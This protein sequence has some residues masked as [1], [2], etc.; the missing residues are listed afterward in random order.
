MDK[1]KFESRCNMLQKL[2]GKNDRGFTLIELM[3]VIAVIG[4]LTAIAIPNFIAYRQKGYDGT[5][6]S[7]VRNAYTAAQD[8]FSNY[9]TGSVSLGILT[10]HGYVQSSDVVL[11]VPSSG[12]NDL[13]IATSHTSGSRTYTVNSSGSIS[14]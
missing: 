3:I 2:R 9:P 14:F 10:A 5:A 8:Y 6:N 11:L 7:D 4:I 12:R 13:Q 1:A